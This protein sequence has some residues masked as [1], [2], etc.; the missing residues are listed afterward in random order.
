ME[1][2]TQWK[3]LTTDITPSTSAYASGDVVGG[4]LTFN[5]VSAAGGAFLNAVR[6]V[7]QEAKDNTFRLWLFNEVP[8][9]IADNAAFT[10]TLANKQKRIGFVDIDTWVD[11]FAKVSDINDALPLPNH[12]LYAYLVL[13]GSTPTYSSSQTISLYLDFLGEGA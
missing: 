12:K 5:Y 4:L 10:Q 9:T 8:A 3:E 2:Y 1:S 6:I 7:D 11:G 13:N